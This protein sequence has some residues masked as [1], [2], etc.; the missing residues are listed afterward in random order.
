VHKKSVNKLLKLT[1]ITLFVTSSI[2]TLSNLFFLNNIKAYENNT[3]WQVTLNINGLD[4]TK[5]SLF[6]GE[7]NNASNGKDQYDMPKPPDPPQ[8]PYIRAWFKTDLE[9]PYNILW[10]DYRS[11]SKEYKI[12]N[13][14]IIW[15]PENISQTEITISWEISE[16]LASGYDLFYLYTPDIVDMKTNNNYQFSSTGSEPH[17]FQIIIQNKDVNQIETNN[18][19][20][21][22]VGLV[23]VIIIIIII[24]VYI[25]KKR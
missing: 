10:A 1:V 6:F 9:E 4:G 14:T 5:D 15:I 22:L 24:A 25:K 8:I 12:W 18:I 17:N 7:K 11:L 21:I 23:I 20:Y 3:E 16:V 13:F 2:F 19:S